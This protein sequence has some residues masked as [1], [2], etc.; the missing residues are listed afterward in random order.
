MESVPSGTYVTGFLFMVGEMNYQETLL[1]SNGCSRPDASNCSSMRLE[2]RV[3]TD[4][5]NSAYA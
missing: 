5:K 1:G 2:S 4:E 3:G